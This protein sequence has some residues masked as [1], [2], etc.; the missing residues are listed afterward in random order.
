MEIRNC[1]DGSSGDMD[2]L[3]ELDLE[4]GKNANMREKGLKIVYN[5]ISSIS[6]LISALPDQDP[7]KILI[8]CP[9]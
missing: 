7:T 6:S 3:V 9:Q 8:R 4:P 1:Q 5:F 2:V